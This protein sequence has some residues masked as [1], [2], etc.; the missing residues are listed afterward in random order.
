M[1]RRSHSSNRKPPDS[2]KTVSMPIKNVDELFKQGF[3]LHQQGQLAQAWQ[4]YLSI[5]KLQPAHADTL[6][7]SG[8]IAA[9][10]NNPL[11]AVEQFNK[12]IEVNPDHVAAIRHPKLA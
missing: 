5:L 2:K 11:L 3:T 8:L 12:A 10:S 6:Y 4:I 1:S 9:Q 7:F